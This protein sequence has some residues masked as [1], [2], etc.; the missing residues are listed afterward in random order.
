[1]QGND[2]NGYG[3]QHPHKIQVIRVLFF[4]HLLHIF[5]GGALIDLSFFTSNQQQVLHHT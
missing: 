2:Q 1:M 5:W 4:L 3:K